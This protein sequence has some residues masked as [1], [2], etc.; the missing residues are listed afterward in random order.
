M[1]ELLV[2]VEQPFEISP[3]R[4]EKFIGRHEEALARQLSKSWLTEAGC[5]PASVVDGVTRSADRLNA[6][7]QTPS[8]PLLLTCKYLTQ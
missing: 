2:K 7:A 6:D 3:W 4:V 5:P 1:S 8:L